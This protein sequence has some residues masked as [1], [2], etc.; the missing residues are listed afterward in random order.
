MKAVAES[1]SVGAIVEMSHV[2]HTV[3]K[4]VVNRNRIKTHI[5]RELQLL[6]RL[7]LARLIFALLLLEHL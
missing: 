6:A 3:S 1:V 4:L 7:L 2:S 5:S